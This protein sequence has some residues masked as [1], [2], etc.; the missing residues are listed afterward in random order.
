VLAF[1]VT[2][3]GVGIAADKLQ[4][5]F[6]AFQQADGST[7]RKYG[8]TGLGLSISRELARLLGGEIR[9]ESTVGS[10]STFTLFLPYNRAGF[11]NYDLPRTQGQLPQVQPAK[12]Q[13][14]PPALEQLP[15][16][17]VPEFDGASR[18][19]TAPPSTTGA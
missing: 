7:A 8:G 4:L 17:H 6:E 14:T 5:I 16:V 3:T 10:G 18:K 1:S 19:S 11:V 15:H 12:V 9:V 2:D 13:Y